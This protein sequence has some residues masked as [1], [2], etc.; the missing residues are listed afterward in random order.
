MTR[1]KKLKKELSKQKLFNSSTG[2]FLSVDKWFYFIFHPIRLLLK[3]VQYNLLISWFLKIEKSKL[4]QILV[5]QH[6]WMSFSPFL[7]KSEKFK[8]SMLVD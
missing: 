4:L 6:K 7:L 1:Q 8:I 2:F 3:S 5:H